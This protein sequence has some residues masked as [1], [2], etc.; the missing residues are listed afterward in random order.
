LLAGL[1]ADAYIRRVQ[2]VSGVLV[3]VVGIEIE[4]GE[5]KKSVQIVGF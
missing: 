2:S 4:S 1:K 3:E 5:M